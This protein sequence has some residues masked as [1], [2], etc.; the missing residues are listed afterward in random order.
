MSAVCVLRNQGVYNSS[1]IHWRFFMVNLVDD[2]TREVKHRC[3]N[4]RE[5][6]CLDT[7]DPSQLLIKKDENKIKIVIDNDKPKMK[8]TLFGVKYWLFACPVYFNADVYEIKIQKKSTNN[9]CI[10][11]NYAACNFYEQFIRSILNL[12]FPE[13]LNLLIQ[14][15]VN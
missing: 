11:R 13:I 3:I 9:T 12:D 2:L 4:N 5:G 6:F 10:L 1:E 8:M 14:Y 15:R 7:K